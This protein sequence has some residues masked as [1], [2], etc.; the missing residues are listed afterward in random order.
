MNNRPNLDPLSSSALERTLIKQSYSAL[1]LRVEAFK[2]AV[3][4]LAKILQ[5]LC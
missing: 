5:L 4:S 2:L 3:R 1:L